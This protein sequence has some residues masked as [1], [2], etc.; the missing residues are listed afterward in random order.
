MSSF[1]TH[2]R[3]VRDPH[4]HLLRRRTALRCCIL[5]LSW[6]MQ[7]P[8]YKTVLNGFNDRYGFNNTPSPSVEQ[9]LETLAAVEQERGIA[10]AKVS[11]FAERRRYEKVHGRHTPSPA[12]VKAFYQSLSPEHS[13]A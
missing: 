2:A 8:S 10:L 1:N 4:L 7:H 5:R 3:K 13:A 6:L 9:L 12:E 11:A